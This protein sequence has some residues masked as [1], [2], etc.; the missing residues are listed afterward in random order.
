MKYSKSKEIRTGNSTD[1]VFFPDLTE[2]ERRIRNEQFRKAAER[3]ARHLAD[4]EQER[5]E[6]EAKTG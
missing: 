3:F 6:E 1:R 5:A 4:L 2:E